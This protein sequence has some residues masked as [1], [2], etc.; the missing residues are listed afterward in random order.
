MQNASIKIALNDHIGAIAI[1]S[2]K[3]QFSFLNKRTQWT[4]IILQIHSENFMKS[5][6][7]CMKDV[8]AIW[9]MRLKMNVEQQRE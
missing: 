3:T 8:E 2:D 4:K 9:I 6:C 7:K 1:Q 5:G